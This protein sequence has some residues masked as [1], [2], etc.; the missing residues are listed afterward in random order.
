MVGLSG[1][2]LVERLEVYGPPE[3]S[4]LLGADHHSVA[5][6]DG[7]AQ[8]DLFQYAEADI[9]VQPCLHLL[10]PVDRYGDGGVARF[11][12]GVGVDLQ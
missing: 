10:L 1:G 3:R 11:G 2:V 12:G 7:C 8:G 4:V 9:P 5:P 6:S